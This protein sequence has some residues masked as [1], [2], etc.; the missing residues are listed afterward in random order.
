MKSYDGLI[1]KYPNL[2]REPIFFE[3]NIGW[4][5]LIEELSSKLDALISKLAMSSY[6][7]Q[8]KEKYGTLRFYLSTETDEMSDLIEIYEKK[9]SQTCEQCSKEGYHQV[10]RGWYVTLCKKCLK[11]LTK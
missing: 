6:A 4:Y 9:S 11:E 5:D 3:C 7:I 10:V 8:V 1:K 2:Y